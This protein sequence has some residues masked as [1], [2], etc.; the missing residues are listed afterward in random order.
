[1]QIRM[2]RGAVGTI[3]LQTADDAGTVWVVIGRVCRI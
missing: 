3:F 2:T 1:M